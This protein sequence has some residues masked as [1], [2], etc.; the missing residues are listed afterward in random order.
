MH[1]NQ[2]P[3]AVSIP[4]VISADIDAS[5]SAC[6]VTPSISI[7]TPQAI[8]TPTPT[9][10]SAHVHAVNNR[11]HQ[12]RTKN[13]NAKLVLSDD[14]AQV[15]YVRGKKKPV[16]DYRD[17]IPPVSK[18]STLFAYIK[19]Q[20]ENCTR[21]R[22]SNPAKHGGKNLCWDCCKS[23]IKKIVNLKSNTAEELQV[24]CQSCRQAKQSK[25]R[26][27]NKKLQDKQLQ[28]QQQ[29]Q[30]E[31]NQQ[32][33][34]TVT[35]QNNNQ[36]MEMI[37]SNIATVMSNQS[38]TGHG[39]NNLDTINIIPTTGTVSTSIYNS[40]Y[41]STNS[42]I[43]IINAHS[44]TS[45]NTTNEL[46]TVTAIQLELQSDSNSNTVN[47]T[48]SHDHDPLQQFSF[49]VTENIDQSQ[50]YDYNDEH[51]HDNQNEFPS[52]L[53]SNEG[54]GHDHDSNPEALDEHYDISQYN[55]CLDEQL[56]TAKLADDRNLPIWL[57]MNQR[58][59]AYQELLVLLGSHEYLSQTTTSSESTMMSITP[60]RAHPS[61]MHSNHV[62]N[63]IKHRPGIVVY[64]PSIE[65]TSNS[66]HTG[67]MSSDFDSSAAAAQTSTARARTHLD[68]NSNTTVTVAST[69]TLTINDTIT[70]VHVNGSTSVQTSDSIRTRPQELDSDHAYEL[71]SIS[72]STDD[73][74]DE[75]AKLYEVETILRHKGSVKTRN[76]E[77]LVKWKGFP[78]NESTWEPPTSFKSHEIIDEYFRSRAQSTRSSKLWAKNWNL[79]RLG[80]NK[81]NSTTGTSDVE[82][83]SD[84]DHDIDM[85][86]ESEDEDD[87]DYDAYND[88]GDSNSMDIDT[89]IQVESNIA[90]G[91]GSVPG[92][93]QC[94]VPDQVPDPTVTVAADHDTITSSMST[95]VRVAIADSEPKGVVKCVSIPNQHPH[96]FIHPDCMVIIKALHSDWKTAT[97]KNKSKHFKKQ[98]HHDHD[99]IANNEHHTN[100]STSSTTEHYDENEHSDDQNNSDENKFN[101]NE[102][103]L[104]PTLF[105]TVR[106]INYKFKE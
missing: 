41:T 86:V 5:A 53:D 10:P 18:N 29:I 42:N 33:G 8:A 9:P 11:K 49:G 100:T 77:F 44:L 34:H 103:T 13:P 27:I 66:I 67:Y 104:H 72:D 61:H 20:G 31:H 47:I 21:Y 52:H 96:R 99:T 102:E 92:F 81:S 56:T 24:Q 89:S 57:Q 76:I 70:S 17:Y 45:M 16:T 50:L 6:I 32:R 98:S 82:S 59:T 83:Q 22:Q 97:S 84:S 65:S 1:I 54:P 64:P 46:T 35:L 38:S 60:S 40:T 26:S 106:G 88:N 4:T 19:C 74:T 43:N 87:S 90:S 14:Y 7:P 95:S 68:F 55:I 12:S 93:V 62:R 48:P 101:L 30:M 71:T 78:R 85:T 58:A 105:H 25:I 15:V 63:I 39:N 36:N 80:I 79:F 73:P 23:G 91:S 28:L 2:I 37:N 69:S 94:H 51:E 75:S 3:A